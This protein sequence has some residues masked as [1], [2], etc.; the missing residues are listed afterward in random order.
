[1]PDEKAGGVY[2]E[3]GYKDVGLKK[4]MN[5]AKAETKSVEKAFDKTE[6]KSADLGK[7]LGKLAAKAGGIAL[8]I[9]GFR[10]LIEFTKASSAAAA[11]AQETQSKF[12]AVFKQNAKEVGAWA[13]A[14]ADSIGRN[15][16][17]QIGFLASVQDT[18][19][20]LGFARSEAA[21][22]SKT[23]VTLSNDLSSFNNIPTA[24]V[25]AGVT[26]AIVGNVENL[27]RYGVVAN[28]AAI[29]TE[30]VRAGLVQEGEA[31]SAEVKARSI[32]NILIAS[33]T[34]A[35]GDL[36]R[37]Q[38]SA[39][40][41]QASL[42]DQ[43]VRTK[44]NYGNFINQALTPLRARFTEFLST[45]NDVV[46]AQKNLDDAISGEAT[47]D[48]TAAVT[49]QEARLINLNRQLD[50]VKTNNDL[51]T[52]SSFAGVASVRA[53]QEQT[54][55]KLEEQISA[56]EEILGQLKD[57][58]TVYD[59]LAASTK[60]AADEADRILQINKEAV[61][62][63]EKQAEALGDY[64][65]VL[66]DFRRD[67]LSETEKLEEDKL[68]ITKQITEDRVA[69]LDSLTQ[70]EMTD[71]NRDALVARY[72]EL[73]QLLI[74]IKAQYVDE[75]ATAKKKADEDLQDKEDKTIADTL[76]KEEALRDARIFIMEEGRKKFLDELDIELAGLKEKGLE[77][78][79]LEEYKTRKIQEFD[80]A[81]IKETE[82]L[83]E[84]NQAIID[85]A[86]A[87]ALN[88]AE[89]LAAAR[90]SIQAD[91]RDKFLDI[92]DSEIEDLKEKGLTEI[93]LEE[94]KTRKIAEYDAAATKATEAKT[95]REEAETKRISD[96]EIAETKRVATEKERAE[97]AL[98]DAK[99]SI[100]SEANVKF[101]AELDREIV[102][103]RAKG[104][105]EIELNKYKEDQI[106]AYNAKIREDE[107]KQEKEANQVIFD[108]TFNLLDN[109]FSI[110]S[111]F[112][113]L[114]T[115]K[116][117]DDLDRLLQEELKT[118]G[119]AEETEIE[120]IQREL[121]AAILAGDAETQAEL[122]KSLERAEIEREFTNKKLELE[123]EGSL[124]SWQIQLGQALLAIPQM[125]QQAYKAVVGTP[126]IGPFIAPA[127]AVVAGGFGI[128]QAALVSENRPVAPT[129]LARGGEISPISGGVPAV[130]AENGYREL[131]FNQGPSGSPFRDEFAQEV[132]KAVGKELHGLRA[133]VDGPL[134]LSLSGKD[135]NGYL[136]SESDDGRLLLNRR[137]I[138]N[139]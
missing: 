41:V 9:Q 65:D 79:E 89:T 111:E 64:Q 48:Y 69:L 16:T 84:V 66:E 121:D 24:E 54:I 118:K 115:Q 117:I 44:E 30:A 68:A 74:D 18:L 103:L 108:Q 47:A 83:E 46:E 20:P 119:L 91:G 129:P 101:K 31:L 25:V 132:A 21:E 27:R 80:E 15:A 12:D 57:S 33:T 10:K 106:A 98:S 1:M 75:I 96:N 131:A 100:I 134:N 139:E 87:K 81:A 110:S 82:R 40:N 109:L 114:T 23:I 58:K 116:R 53:Q 29:K 138:I 51:I 61:E 94:Y 35:Q 70:A 6:K 112:S 2:I 102:D 4:G 49:E 122:E 92:L 8:L 95:K 26:S 52:D 38:D 130:L 42:T 88:T 128:A 126:I 97:R 60:A 13:D 19:V 11:D 93:E 67:D 3:I 62:L 78:L 59:E 86:A 39:A 45:L 22:F 124:A 113:N 77:E 34:D 28:E 32:M 36:V 137:V 123:Y 7:T 5:E 105:T 90:I 127:A 43:I 135:L 63:L 72:K 14:Y 73:G 133:I 104:I 85:K 56:Q 17:A 76:S 55:T 37:T 107:R 71:E 125:A 120:R 136:R 50:T 99:T